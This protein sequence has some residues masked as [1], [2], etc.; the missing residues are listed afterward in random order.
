VRLGSSDCN[1]ELVNKAA[2]R[3]TQ[4]YLGIEYVCAAVVMGTWSGLSDYVGR[5]QLMASS[6]MGQIAAVAFALAATLTTS[7]KT[8]RRPSS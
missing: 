3:S 4:F 5:K 1:S 8:V 7:Y 2:V 6:A